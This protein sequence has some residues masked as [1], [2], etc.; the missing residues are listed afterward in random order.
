MGFLNFHKG[1]YTPARDDGTGKPVTDVFIKGG[2]LGGSSFKD[3]TLH[4]S[5]TAIGNGTEIEI[6][7]YKLLNIKI[8]G[9]STSRTIV[10]E[11]AGFDG[12]YEPIQGVRVQDF[13]MANQS[14]G[15]NESWQIDVTGFDSFRARITAIAGGNISIRGKAV[16]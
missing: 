12:V 2:S 14:T 9:T 8:T 1:E 16:S 11:V 13:S 3:V 10:F 5:T 15:N 7:S 4:G 6:D